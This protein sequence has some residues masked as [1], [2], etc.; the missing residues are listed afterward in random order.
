MLPDYGEKAATL[1]VMSIFLNFFIVYA[2][3]LILGVGMV[4][5]T[6]NLIAKIF[7][8]WGCALIARSKGYSYLW[9]TLGAIP[10][11]GLL[12]LIFLPGKY[13]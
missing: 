11:I 8:I 1:I 10:L 6:I 4:T 7:F 9:G 2:L 5:Q 13:K 3:A 12:I